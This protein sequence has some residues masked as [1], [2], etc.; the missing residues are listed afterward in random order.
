LQTEL[1]ELIRAEIGQRGPQSFSWF[2]EQALYHPQHGYYASGRAAMGRRGD[3]FTNVSVGPFFG[4]LLAAQ[5]AEMWERIDKVGN[6]ILVEQGAHHG[7]FA[8]D[9]LEAARDHSPEFFSAARYQI[10]EPSPILRDRQVRR[11]AGFADKVSWRKSL[12]DLA[13][14]CGVHFSNELIDSMPVHLMI[15][16][17]DGWNEKIVDVTG[18]SF[19]F[20]DRPIVDDAVR[21]RLERLPARPTG[22]ETELNLAALDWIDHLAAKLIRG[23][24][25]MVDYGFPRDEFYAPSRT[26]GT[27]QVRARHRRLSGPFEQIGD[28]D[29]SA[30]V[31]W[32]EIAG[33][34]EVNGLRVGGFTDQHHFVAGIISELLRDKLGD[35][36][37]PK[38]RRALQ[39]LLHPEML[40]RT[41]QVL[42]LQKDL[43]VREPL[44]GFTFAS[45][46]RRALGI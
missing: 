14:F 24:A 35:D 7:E 22:Y 23:Y 44:S 10:I 11:L 21:A 41:F 31:N 38:A 9:V 3:Y 33:H 42:A 39:T 25:L 28:A 20:A 1:L 37:D 40:G 32:T 5:F 4:R 45:D 29:I 15:S 19:V 46:G 8:L 16:T 43:D 13:P 30:H 18:E 17:G 12:D 2:M 26:V 34:A 6:F 36:A 27:L